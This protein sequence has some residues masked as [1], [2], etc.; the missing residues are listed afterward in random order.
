VS[1]EAWPSA[2]VRWA[3]IHRAAAPGAARRAAAAPACPRRGL[4]T[5]SPAESAPYVCGSQSV[6]PAGE[7]YGVLFRFKKKGAAVLGLLWQ[8]QQGEW[9]IAAYRAFEQ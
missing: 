8:R 1:A 3:S 4:W 7:Y 2:G 5:G 9:R 6:D